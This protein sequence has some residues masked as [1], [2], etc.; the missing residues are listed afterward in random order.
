FRI[1][2][3]T[4]GRLRPQ[5]V[6]VA[7]MDGN[8]FGA[9]LGLALLEPGEGVAGEESVL[10][11]KWLLCLRVY[12]GSLVLYLSL[13]LVPTSWIYFFVILLQLTITVHY[14]VKLTHGSTYLF[15]YAPDP[16]RVMAG[17]GPKAVPRPPV[18][19]LDSADIFLDVIHPVIQSKCSSCHNQNKTKGQLLL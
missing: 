17:M 15:Q 14:G 1:Y 4:R 11:I 7:S 13:W 3:V 16:I 9:R 18:T 10:K 2:V 8:R 12:P 5:H 6:V 19:V